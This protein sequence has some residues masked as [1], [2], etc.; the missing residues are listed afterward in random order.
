LLTELEGLPCNLAR[1]IGGKRTAS[2]AAPTMIKI[3]LLMSVL[4]VLQNDYK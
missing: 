1:T 4:S 3:N 2:H